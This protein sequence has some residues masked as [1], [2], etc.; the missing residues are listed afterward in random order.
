MGRSSN[1]PKGRSPGPPFT[2]DVLRLFGRG[3]GL[4]HAAADD[5]VSPYQ[6]RNLDFVTLLD[7]P[8]RAVRPFLV[9]R[10]DDWVYVLRLSEKLRSGIT[11]LA[12][13]GLDWGPCHHDMTLD[14]VHLTADGRVIFYDFDSGGPGWRS[15]D[16]QSVYDYSVYNQ[17][18]HWDAFLKG[19]SEVRS[20]GEADLAAVPYFVL[21]YGFWDLYAAIIRSR[22][23]GVSFLNDEYFDER[24]GPN[25]WWRQ[26]E[27]QHLN[28]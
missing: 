22:W 24:V 28:P 8:L 10:P 1:S 6:R 2:A 17:N 14:N 11:R 18:D 3:A 13:S 26:W 25:G 19:Y 23:A 12:R 15:L 5:F 7:D 27:G 20:L 4:I 9:H 21:V 16:F